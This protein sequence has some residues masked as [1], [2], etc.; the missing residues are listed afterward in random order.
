MNVFDEIMME[1]LNVFLPPKQVRVTIK[2]KSYINADLEKLDRLKKREYRKHRRS[3]KYLKRKTK[4]D[5]EL[6]KAA[7]DHLEKN[8]RSLKESSPGRA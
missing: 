6:E 5:L 3:E 2:D 1:N 4:F 8:V 7:S